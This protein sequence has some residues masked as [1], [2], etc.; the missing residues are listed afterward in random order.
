VVTF[1]AFAADQNITNVKEDMRADKLNIQ[2][3]KLALQATKS[4]GQN[5]TDAKA[6]VQADKKKLSADKQ[7]SQVVKAAKRGDAQNKIQNQQ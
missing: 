7:T 5:V 4:S 1:S 3:E 2:S 6:A